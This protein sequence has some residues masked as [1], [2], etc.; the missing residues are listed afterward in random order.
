V[1]RV[2]DWDWAAAERD[3]KEALRL[4]P[5]DP[6]AILNLAQV[7][8]ALGRWKEAAGLS[9]TGLTL[10]PLDAAWY[11]Q[12]GFVHIAT[13]RLSEVETDSRKVLQISPTFFEGHLDLGQALLLQ[14]NF[15]GALAE[16]QQE[17]TDASRYV[18]LAMV[19]HALGR[20]AESDAALA[21]VVHEHAQDDASEIADV[22]AYRGEV[23]HAFAWLDRAYSQKDTGLS[24]IKYDPFFK[25]LKGDP[26]YKAFLRKMNLPE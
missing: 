14:G 17:R 22:Y 18:G 19:Y 10:E 23:D 5:H 9:E 15:Q 3:A 16:M 11:W 25:N 12:L 8:I 26:R 7:Y 13:G 2:Y 24:V 21:Q 4:K 20:R 1:R 6:V